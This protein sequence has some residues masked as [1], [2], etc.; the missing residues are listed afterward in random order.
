MG[1]HVSLNGK[2]SISTLALQSFKEPEGRLV[3]FE[4][5]DLPEVSVV[6]CENPKEI[7]TSDLV[8]CAP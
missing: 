8:S 1:F 7:A 5:A 2:P 4:T 6:S 3:S